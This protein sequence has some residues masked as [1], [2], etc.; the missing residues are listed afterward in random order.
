MGN[1]YLCG[2]EA[3]GIEPIERFMNFKAN[4]VGVRM[5]AIPFTFP[6]PPM[7]TGLQMHQFFG[8]GVGFKG[9][10]PG[11]K[12]RVRKGQGRDRL[13][14]MGT[15]NFWAKDGILQRRIQHGFDRNLVQD[16]GGS[17]GSIAGRRLATLL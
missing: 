12:V 4:T 7:A 13:P 9:P 3:L 6:L 11:T 14:T 8:V 15:Q 1:G 2:P 10:M 16:G 5:L 17:G